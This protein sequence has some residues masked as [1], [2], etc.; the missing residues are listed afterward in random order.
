[1]I[2]KLDKLIGSGAQADVYCVGNKAIKL[3]KEHCLKAEVFYEAAI[4]SMVENIKLP[5]PKI[6]EV[7]EYKGRMAIV[8]DLIEGTSMKQIIRNDIN[9][10]DS[11]IDIIIDLQIKIHSINAFG[12]PKMKD[13]LPQCITNSTVLNNQQKEK[14]M[15][16]L[17]RFNKGISLCHGDYHFNNLIMTNKTLMVIDWVDATCGSPEADL[18][19]TYMLYSLYAPKGF[20]D[21]YLNVY[22]QKTNKAHNEILKWLPIIA[23]ARLSEKNEEEKDKL[24]KWVEMDVDKLNVE[25]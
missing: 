4:H 5:I 20:A 1:M 16:L 23:G 10:I 15:V 18:C 22:C 19:R 11:Y 12:F 17:N 13:R 7:I 2:E 8:M 21:M 3:F 6:Y 9:N 14:L 24:I 25:W